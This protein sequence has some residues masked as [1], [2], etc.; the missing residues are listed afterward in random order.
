MP[1]VAVNTPDEV[2]FSSLLWDDLPFEG[3]SLEGP[4]GGGSDFFIAKFNASGA[5]Q[6]I[7]EVPGAGS[8]SQG[9]QNFLEVDHQGNVSFVGEFKGNINWGV[10]TTV[11]SG[12]FYYDALF[13][14][15]DAE[16]NLLFVKTANS[17]NHVRFDS[18]V[19][20]SE[21]SSYL[22]GLGYNQV[23]MDELLIGNGV[24]AYF[25]F[26]TKI[27]TQGLSVNHPEF[28]SITVYP[29]PTENYLFVDGVREN[30]QATLFNFLGQKVK[31]VIVIPSEPL[32]ITDLPSGIYLLKTEKH[33]PVKFVKK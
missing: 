7:R 27:S 6:W 20:D 15:Y 1:Q 26:L 29:N 31:D 28:Q 30:T 12:V 33:T 25:P 11:S 18:I 13:L 8:V 32:N 14:K 16:G 2:Y 10:Q 9:S 24:N 5:I 3:I 17:E 22:S 21:G 23:Q 19:T 4:I